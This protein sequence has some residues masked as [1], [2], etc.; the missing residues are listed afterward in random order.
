MARARAKT[1]DKKYEARAAREIEDE[2]DPMSYLYWLKEDNLLLLTGWARRGLSD[3]DIIQLMGVTK[4]MYS[5]WY[6]KYEAIRSALDIGKE[7]VDFKVENALLKAALGYQTK[8]VRILTVMRH[9][10]LVEQQ[11]EVTEKEVQ[12]Q[13]G[14]IRMWLLNRQPDWWKNENKLS[15]DDL[16][17]DSKIHIDVTRA[18]S[19][20]MDTTSESKKDT[21][22]IA[23]RRATKEE[24][25]QYIDQKKAEQK[26]QKID[27][28]PP[29]TVISQDDLSKLDPDDPDYWPEDDA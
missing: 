24:Q 22:H 9:G 26:Q 7:I 21:K 6:D 4:S 14:A 18:T 12:P 15:V 16:L 20:N 2:N 27:A 8:E 19:G 23:V 11:K 5:R 17:E 1:S 25:K 10:K 29:L 13:I 3:N 28:A